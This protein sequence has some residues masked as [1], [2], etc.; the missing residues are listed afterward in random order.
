MRTKLIFTLALFCIAVSVRAA[1]ANRKNMERM[2]DNALDLSLRQS[3]LMYNTL[4]DNKEAFPRTAKD[5]ELVICNSAWWTSGFF[6]GTLWYLYENSGNAD[7]LAAAEEMTSRMAKEQYNT[8]SHDVGFM[9]NCSYGN[10]YRITG[11]EEYRNAVINAGRSLATRFDPRIGCVRSWNNRAWQFSVIIDNMMNL[12][13]LGVASSFTGD[14]SFNDKAISHAVKTM[15]YHYRPDGSSYHVVQYDSITGELFKRHTHQGISDESSWSRGQA[16]GLYGYVM[17][18]RQTGRKEFL[19]HAIKIADYLRNHPNLPKDKIPYWDYDAPAGTKTYRDAS[20]GAL[21]ASA[22]IE[23]STYTEGVKSTQYLTLA[24]EMLKSFCSP[25]YFAK[26]GENSNFIIKHCTGFVAKNYEI[27]APLSYGDYYFVEALMRYK[28]LINNQPVVDIQTSF[29]SNTDRAVWLSSLD[30]IARPLLTNMSEGKLKAN[31]TVESVS[32]I[33]GRKQVTYLEALGRLLTGIAPW[34]ELGPDAT[35]EGRL[36]EKY[37]D[38]AVKS[39]T[40]GVDPASA[41]YLNFNKGRQPL[42][43]AAFLSHALLR[44]KTQLWD[45]LDKITQQRLIAELKSSRVIV[46]SE[47]NWLFFSAMVEAALKEFDGEWEFQRVKYAFDRHK[48]WYKGD[49]W[50]GDGADFHLDYYNSFVIQPMMMQVLDVMKRHGVD[51]AGF[52]E[53]E[54]QRYTRYAAQQ[55]RLISPEG[56]YPIVG[57]SLA[58]RF[59]AFYALSDAAYRGML[60]Q[61]VAPGQVRNA[62]TTLIKRQINAPGTFD[63]RGWLRVGVA[64]Y[65]P[66]IG[67]TYIS[68]GSLYLCSAVFIALGLPETDAF[69]SSPSSD[70]TSKKA[71]SGADIKVDKALKQ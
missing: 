50:Y 71:W 52:G 51:D 13:L 36:R 6:P 41:D 23:L 12:E 60:P 3:M 70:W 32:D 48:E 37:I 67:E 21:I 63:D 43:D 9:I 10:G 7:V 45:R 33:E 38:L 58:Y 55:E 69:W 68:T 31:M 14:N 34:L 59:G 47:T 11:K 20:A 42:V 22:L 64:G 61:E 44:A 56:T 4:K 46:P 35:P 28:R 2:V 25:Q 57:R 19:D 27:D 39:I 26:P 24:E 53:I 29:S 62:L 66:G 5:G 16:W 40:N 65:Q 54:K 18:Y 30:R 8:A 15:K 1:T 17:M 49:G